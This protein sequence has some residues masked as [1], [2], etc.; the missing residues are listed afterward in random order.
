MSTIAD[1]RRIMDA[2][3]Q[4]LA[5]VESFSAWLALTHDALPEPESFS[6][7][8]QQTNDSIEKDKPNY[9]SHCE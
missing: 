5:Y 3:E 1:I 2:P 7:F 8:L 9:A 6:E 4:D